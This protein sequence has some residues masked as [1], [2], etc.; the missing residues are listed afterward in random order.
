MS[1]PSQNTKVLIS[2]GVIIL[3]GLVGGCA[4][5]R[6]VWTGPALKPTVSEVQKETPALKSSSGV[7]APDKR[8]ET[9][10]GDQ[11]VNITSDTMHYRGQGR[12]AV[13]RGKVRVNQDDAWLFTPYLEVRSDDGL[14]WARQGIRL[15]DYM[16]DV[17]VT[18][19]ELKYFKDLS[20]AT[21]RK[22]VSL[23]TRDERG[24]QLRIYSRSMEWNAESGTAE[25]REKVVVHYLNITATAGKMTYDHERQVLV[26]TQDPGQKKSLPEVLRGPD[27]LTG[28]TITLHVKQQKYEVQGS[29]RAVFISSGEKEKKGMKEK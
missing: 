26:L 11:P 6:G 12:V 2:A 22:K 19:R 14:A 29:A 28:K 13:F 8:L 17:T 3:L 1:M 25:A 18:A 20:R 27:K 10:S 24:N 4:P 5:W 16:R 9:P 7:K 21:I 15:V 23:Q